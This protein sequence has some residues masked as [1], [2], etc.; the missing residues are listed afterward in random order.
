[1]LGVMGRVVAAA[2]IPLLVAAACGVLSPEEQLLADFFEASRLYDTTVVA[3]MS[4]VVFN[5]RTD[6]VVE[7]F[8]VEGVQADGE[9]KRVTV[10]ATVRQLNGGTRERTLAFTMVR[11]GDR[12]FITAWE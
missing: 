4:S 8:D 3:R 5:P 2:L 6:G 12:W 7:E 9:S 10:R 11:K 1:M